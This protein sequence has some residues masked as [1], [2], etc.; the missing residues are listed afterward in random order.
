MVS[1]RSTTRS[2]ARK[3]RTRAALLAAAR[4]LFAERGFEDTT[5]AAIGERA[6]LGFG[7][8]YLYFKDKEDILQTVLQEGFADL[9]AHVDQL[10]ADNADPLGVA[11][12]LLQAIFRYAYDN[13]E[14]FRVLLRTGT[15][16]AALDAQLVFRGRVSRA[17]AAFLPEQDAEI[18][19][20]M[21]TGVVTQSILWWFD[22]DQPGPDVLAERTQRF[23]FYGLFG[24]AGAPALPVSAITAD[25]D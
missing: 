18:T 15:T 11:G 20:R 13:L 8:F 7:T 3:Q 21:V 1:A 12:P 6:G 4:G 23:I 22:H 17:L 19:A 9:R 25:G 10:V 5:I 16:V 14:L 2:E 24:A